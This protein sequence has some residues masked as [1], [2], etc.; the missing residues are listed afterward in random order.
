MNEIQSPTVEQV[1]RFLKGLECLEK[2][3]P[4]RAYKP[5]RDFIENY[6][7][8]N[9]QNNNLDNVLAKS[10][11]LDSLYN[12]NIAR[13]SGDQD[14]MIQIAKRIV[15]KKTNFDHRLKQE[16]FELVNE[17]AGYGAKGE[18]V[19]NYSFATKYCSLHSPMKYSIYDSNVDEALWYF[20][21]KDRSFNFQRCELKDCYPR[22][23]DIIKKFKKLYG[24]NKFDLTKIDRYL[25]LVGGHLRNKSR[26]KSRKVK[27]PSLLT[28]ILSKEV[29]DGG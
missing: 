1:E 29:C 19:K 6:F 7:R 9:P 10:Y 5:Q 12:T 2:T 14:R 13:F 16:D 21:R 15:C 28:V 4:W 20:Q 23:A 22:Y 11:L 17:I 27:K 3:V 24:L 25:W 8:E 18:N 26:N